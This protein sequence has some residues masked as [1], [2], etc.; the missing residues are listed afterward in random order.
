MTLD[1][2]PSLNLYVE[3]ALGRK[4]LELV[5]LDVLFALDLLAAERHL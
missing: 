1:L 5:V 4:A 3:A 2:D